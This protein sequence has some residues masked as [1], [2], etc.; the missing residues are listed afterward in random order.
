MTT[1]RDDISESQQQRETR[2]RALTLAA[3]VLL[4]ATTIVSI[5]A[6]GYL[7][8]RSVNQSEDNAAQLASIATVNDRLVDCTE[9]GGKCFEAGQKRTQDA[10]VGINKGTL[11]VIVA[12]LSCQDD[13]ITEQRALARCTVERA[14]AAQSR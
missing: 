1:P 9:P 6:V 10:V 8:L 11:A 7:A 4:L 5:A 13:G 12:A 2:A 3:I 14:Q